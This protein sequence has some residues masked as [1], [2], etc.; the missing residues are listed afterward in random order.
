MYTCTPDNLP[1]FDKIEENIVLGAG[2]SG[3]GFKHSPSTGKILSSLALGKENDLPQGYQ[4][5]RFKLDRFTS[6]RD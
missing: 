5:S 2:F 1:I 3:S 6:L 4:R